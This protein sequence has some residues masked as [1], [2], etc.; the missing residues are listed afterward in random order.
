M[1]ASKVSYNKLNDLVDNKDKILCIHCSRQNL[2]DNEDGRGTPR[3]I[4]IIIKSLDGQIVKIFAIHL[5]AEKA[6]IIWEEVENY[7]DFLEERMLSAFNKFVHNYREYFWL[8]WNM[9]GVHFGFEALKH[10]YCVLID[11]DA[12]GFNEVP[13]EKRTNL[14][15]LLKSIYN[16]NYEKEPM[17]QNLMKSNNN[18]HFK[19]GFL[20][21]E[22]EALAF[23]SLDFPKILESIICK[24]DFLIYI[25]NKASIRKLKV[26]NK[27]FL[28]KL[29]MFITN[30]IVA[31]ITTI[32]TIIGM[33]LGFLAIFEG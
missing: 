30:P 14:N 25:I 13:V 3:T 7:Y 21:I 10:R 23:K 28:I 15:T 12:Q 16:D 9:D 19:P 11:E 17:L 32:A 5:E 22:E 29:E 33:I 26:S 1:K 2:T 20:S 27:R 18:G 8:H 6:K 31:F 24:V 4:A